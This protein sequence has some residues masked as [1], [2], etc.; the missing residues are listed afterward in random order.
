MEIDRILNLSATAGKIML[1]SGGEIYRVEE[2]IFTICKSF[3]VEEVDVFAST[4]SIMAT[5]IDNGKI[6]TIVKRITN[7]G[8]NLNMVQKINT[9]SRQIYSEKPDIDTCEK[10]LSELSK[11]EE[12]SLLKRLFFAGISTSTFTILFGGTVNDFI[13]AFLLGIIVQYISDRLS[14]TYLNLFFRNGLCGA[15]V[16]LTSIIFM[17]IGFID[18][19]DK[20]IAGTI[21]LLVPGL[22]L[23]NAIR[24][25]LE[26]QLVAGLTK[27]AEATFV[28]VS[29]AVGTFIIIKL[30]M[31]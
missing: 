30:L 23:T 13:L 31:I 4:T 21:M 26:G 15:V 17:R 5:I 22:S 3:G 7:R 28:G 9:L 25:I 8:V 18:N 10:Q 27:A 20:L 16:A 1:E 14:R 12:Y 6:H 19:I 29:T 2:T 24:D 11:K